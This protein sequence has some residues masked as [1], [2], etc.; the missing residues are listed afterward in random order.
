MRADGG[1]FLVGEAAFWSDQH[2]AGSIFQRANHR[3]ATALVTEIESALGGPI[4]EQCIELHQRCNFG[5]RGAL[6]L[7][8]SLNHLRV[9]PIFFDLVDHAARG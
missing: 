5:K 1:I 9:Q 2:C 7:F 6:A 4:L 3:L 8:S